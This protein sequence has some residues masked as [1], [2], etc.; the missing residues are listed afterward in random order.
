MSNF[1]VIQKGVEARVSVLKGANFLA[2]AVKS[3]LGP[4]GANCIM[5]KGNR[6]TNDGVSISEE[7]KSGIENELERRGAITLHES[8][9]K[10][11][12]EVGD[13][14]TTAI[15]LAQSIL[16]E[17]IRFLPNEKSIAG[18]KTPI[19]VINQ[20]EKER[21]EIVEKLTLMATPIETEEQLINSA[22][23]AVE[24]EE[25]GK[26]IGKAQWELGKEGRLIVQDTTDKF[27]SV[28]K[29]NGIRIDNGFG[30][31]L[32]QNKPEKEA[33]E[34]DK[35]QVILTN[36]TFRDFQGLAHILD[37]L[38]KQGKKEVVIIGRAFTEEAIKLCME[39]HKNGFNLYPINAPYVNQIEVM[40]DLESVLGGRFLNVESDSI[41]DIMISD[42]GFADKIVAKRFYAIFT[43]SKNEIAAKNIETRLKVLELDLK[44][45]PNEFLKRQI[46]ERI[47]Q[48]KN[49]FAL[50][51]VGSLSETE[52][53]Y[54]LDKAEDAVNAVRA[55]FQEGT[56]KGGGLAF[57]EI[58]DSLSD[59]Y[60]LKRPLLSIYEQIM[61]TAP[62][63]FKIPDTVRDPLKVLR[64]ALQN[65]CSVASTFASVGIAIAT[66]NPHVCKCA[67]S[68]QDVQE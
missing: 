61:S 56:V 41:E 3:T 29:I 13:G 1:K 46:L 53:K 32:V 22:T 30:T 55:A 47:A 34:A 31:S 54:K 37:Q 23:V 26:L 20:I 28:E 35:V 5:E 64:V 44:G 65:A 48:L 18:K 12:D 25:L 8:A 38:N 17:A 21:K 43:G 7:I 16:K 9:K 68:L 19:E 27:S 10:T 45:A 15:T 57:K 59:D 62:S 42:I 6:V 60:I 58:S 36:F 39:N 52:A 2:D 67:G 40:K 51:K 66:K 24:D 33:L 50:V 4:W 63:D 14:T 49:G 11:N